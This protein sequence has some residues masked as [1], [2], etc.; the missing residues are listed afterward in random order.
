[1]KRK[2]LAKRKAVNT[3]DSESQPSDGPPTLVDDS[4]LSEN[5][6][7]GASSETSSMSES[8]GDPGSSIDISGLLNSRRRQMSSVPS[9]SDKGKGKGTASAIT[10]SRGEG[11]T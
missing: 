8:G 2:H 10:T 7:S 1:M 11:Q 9:S 3:S 4:S 6:E 5:K